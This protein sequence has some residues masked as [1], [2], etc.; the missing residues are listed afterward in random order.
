MHYSEIQTMIEDAIYRA[1]SDIN[2]EL[3]Q[4]RRDIDELKNTIEKLESLNATY[5]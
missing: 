4:L 5:Q 2:D 3:K 1:N